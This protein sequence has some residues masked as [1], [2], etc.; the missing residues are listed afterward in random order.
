[1]ADAASSTTILFTDSTAPRCEA[2]NR[3]PPPSSSIAL[4]DGGT[5]NFTWDSVACAVGYQVRVF[6]PNGGVVDL[7]EVTGTTF[8][9]SLV[10]GASGFSIASVGAGGVLG[11]Y[12][13]M[14]GIG[15]L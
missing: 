12:S 15:G 5:V 10:S 1:M 11:P 8:T 7:G 9:S 4:R 3:P 13:G 14:Q 2:S 6:Y